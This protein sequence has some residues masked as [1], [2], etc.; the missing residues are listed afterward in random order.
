M[1]PPTYYCNILILLFI[2]RRTS[3]DCSHAFLPLLKIRNSGIKKSEILQ[4]KLGKSSCS[5]TDNANIL[6]DLLSLI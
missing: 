1:D 4:Q 3:D 2:Y 5:F 6:E